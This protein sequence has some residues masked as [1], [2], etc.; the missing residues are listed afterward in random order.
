MA[1]YNKSFN[2]RNG[3]QVDNDNFIVNANGLVGIGTSVPKEF[4][5]VYGTAK[6]TGLVTATNLYVSGVATFS[7]LKIGNVSIASSGIITA[8][9]GIITYYG[10]GG[11]L[12]NLPTSQWIDVNSGFGYTSI[13]AAGNVGIATTYPNYTFQVGG[14]PTISGG[15]GFNSTGDV[16][17]SGIITATTANITGA[18]T[19]NTLSATTITGASIQVSG[20]GTFGTLNAN[21]GIITTLSGT[22]IRYNGIGTFG[23]LNASVGVVTTLSGA[24]LTYG[25]AGITTLNSTITGSITNLTN[26]N[27]TSTAST[28]TFLTN[29][30]LKTTGI[31]TIQ[32]LNTVNGSIS[33]LTGESISVNSN[34]RSD[35]LNANSG[36]V[37]AISGTNLTYSGTGAINTLNATTGI[38]TTLSGTTLNYDG[39]GTFGALTSPSGTINNLSSTNINVSGVTTSSGGFVGNLTGNVT[40]IAASA[41][42]LV[43]PRNFSITGNFVTAPT[44]SFNG[45]G[46]VAFAATITPNSIGLGTYTNGNYVKSIS[47]TVNQIDVSAS[48]TPGGEPQISLSDTVNIFGDL[49]VENKVGIGTTI[50]QYDLDITLGNGSRVGI[51]TLG[52][53]TATG[54]VSTSQLYVSGVTTS[55]GGFVGNI[56][57]DVNS[58]GPSTFSGGIIGNLTGNVIG[59]ASTAL[60]LSGTPNI[61]VGIVTATTF[62][63]NLTGNVT[64]IASTALSLSGTPNITVGVITATKLVIGTSGTTLTTN[65]N[66]VGIGTTNPKGILDLVSTTQPFY[67]P[68]MTTVQRDAIVGISSGAMV[69]NTTVKEFQ[70][71]TGTAWVTIGL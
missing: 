64:G 30:N 44:I 20:A 58:T 2:F 63:G 14:N 57:G 25:T 43:T 17:I 62:N 23:T 12:L 22:N 53:I 8:T 11:N 32:T 40:G 66:S 41:T 61:V 51:S 24:S 69:F 4:L 46:N 18:T 26:T 70:A 9:T 39:T 13:Y 3:V 31:A 27:L 21:S 34:I 50:P 42:Q 38:V 47:G 60:S 29:T 10:N 15:V 54:I 67:L 45:T 1:N 5:D 52:N 16:Y 37:T 65:N 55:I 36:V 49:Y 7:N 33:Y 35:T 68:R 19:L 56:T 71:Y 6:F 28:I 59:I 48:P